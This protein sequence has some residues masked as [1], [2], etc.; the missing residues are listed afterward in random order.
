M[1]VMAA[2]YTYKYLNCGFIAG[3]SGSC[4]VV[5]IGEKY[6]PSGARNK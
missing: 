6:K 1:P 5:R 4:S 3:A 2:F